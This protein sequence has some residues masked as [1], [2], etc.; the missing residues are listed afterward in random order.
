MPDVDPYVLRPGS[1]TMVAARGRNGVIGADGDMPWRIPEDFAHFKRLTTGHVLI[2]G[3][4]TWDAIGR[5]LP[6]RSTVVLTRDSGWHDERAAV[7]HSLTEALRLAADLPG[8]AVI[9]GGAQIYGQALPV[10][11]HQVV[12]EVD[13]APD[14][15]T[16]YPAFDETEWTEELRVAGPQCVWRWLARITRP[17]P[18]GDNR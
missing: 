6:G 3:R 12:T 8:E 5:P 7:A 2:M 1:I 4:S 11:T 18:P 14:G 16:V 10:A 13:L 17:G 9:A 15:D